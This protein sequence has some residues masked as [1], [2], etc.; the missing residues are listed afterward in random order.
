MRA[1]LLLAVL[2]SAPARAFADPGYQPAY[3]M[4]DA[5]Q[6]KATYQASMSSI[7]CM[8]CAASA[9]AVKAAALARWIS[10]CDNPRLTHPADTAKCVAF[11]R[12][13]LGV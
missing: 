3:S 2:L 9:Q 13:F 5:L 4:A 7:T 12:A 10:D 6:A 8:T 11:G 1:A